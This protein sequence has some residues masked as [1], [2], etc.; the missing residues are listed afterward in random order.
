MDAPAMTLDA[1]DVPMT[2]AAADPAAPALSR[3]ARL[4]A[5][6]A[7]GD[8]RSFELLYASYAPRVFR[9]AFRMIRDQSKAEEVTNDVMLDIWKG[10]K[11]FEGRSSPAT[12]IFG[13]ARH[14]TL[15]AVRGRTLYL[16][17]LEEASEVADAAPGPEARV[18]GSRLG[19]RLQAALD[20]LSAEHREVIELTFVEGKSYKEI[21]EIAHCPENTI[22][23]RMFHAKKKLAP[24][25]RAVLDAGAPQ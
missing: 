17:D 6:I 5:S 23:T 25:L 13:V 1:S 7:R 4:L 20:R 12:W 14:R 22:K 15:N 11:S 10:A 2:P 3:D 16:A 18:D 8:R 21:A 9:F 19:E 24:L